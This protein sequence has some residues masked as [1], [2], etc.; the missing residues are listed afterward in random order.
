MAGWKI[1]AHYQTKGIDRLDDW[2]SSAPANEVFEWG[3]SW[4]PSTPSQAA[5]ELAGTEE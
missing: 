4:Y 3:T 5:E 2:I 1:G